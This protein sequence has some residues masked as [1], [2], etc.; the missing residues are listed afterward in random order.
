MS[1][2]VLVDGYTLFVG[3]PDRAGVAP[4]DDG[5][6]YYR[7][8]RHLSVLGVECDGAE[9]GTVGRSLPAANSRTVVASDDSPGV[10]RVDEDDPKRSELVL[11]TEQTVAEGGEFLHR[12]SVVNHSAAPYSGRVSVVFDVDFADI[13]EV[14]GFTSRLDRAP[15]TT[16][17]DS[18]VTFAYEYEAADG[19]TET[20]KTT[21]AFD[22]EP[23]MLTTTRASFDVT[24]GPQQRRT[25][26]CRVRATAP[27]E[28][29]AVADGSGPQDH[30]ASLDARGDHH[31]ADL[32][33]VSTGRRDYD[34]VFERAGEDLCALTAGTEHGP[35]PLAGA[36]WFATVFGR[37][38]LIAAY[39]A[40]PV[41]PSLA[42][43]TIRYLATYQGTSVDD[44]REEEPGKIFH[45]IRNGELTR[46][47]RIPHSPYYGSVDATP[48]WVVLLAELHRWTGDDGFVADVEVALDRAVDWITE[49]MAAHADDP[50][51]YY[52]E[53]PTMGLLHKAWRDTPGSVQF[54]DGTVAESPIA[55]VEVQ[56][57]A[58]R[59]L[60]DAA[61]LYE[62]VLDDARRAA[63]LRD[64]AD[65][66]ADAFGAT[67]WLPDAGYYGVAKDGGGTTVPTH[68]S[69]VGH[70]LWSG[71]VPDD[72]AADVATTLVSGD[73]FSGW[74][75]RTMSAGAAGYSPVSYHIG[76]VWPHDTSLAAL[77]LSRYGFSAKANDLTRAVLDASTQF[78]DCR[79]PEL[80]CGFEDDLAPKP[81]ASSCVP[82]A[83][84]AGAPYALLRAAFGVVPTGDGVEI[85]NEDTVLDAG[86]LEPIRDRW[87]R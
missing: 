29:P 34:R 28:A 30:P 16:I 4:D 49:S 75:I 82:Q 76:S 80:F 33:T 68:T 77:G 20:R 78:D 65:R 18:A 22:G 6:L 23:A 56:G 44:A 32:P 17:R 8:T 25:I 84:S 31:E 9:L 7:D 15:S 37:D 73:L 72:R 3:D 79:I 46:R 48:L 19:D 45:E 58:Y 71:I 55:S 69:N 35:V 47:D 2:D 51:V 60:R 21:V 43:G 66:L 10:N 38:S 59:A 36:P 53:S 27:G 11:K 61:G 63:E 40:L 14:R 5:G 1:R 52:E 87:N 74:G 81:Y 85:E 24:L 86:A 64:R 42:R 39:Q 41:A 50:F 83:W 13:F 12:A 54:P 57:Y 62:S 67:F 70:C 26:T